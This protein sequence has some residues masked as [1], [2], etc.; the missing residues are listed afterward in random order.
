[1]KQYTIEEIKS[2]FVE[3]NYKWFDFH[4]VGIRSN[5]NLAN[6]F[7]DLIGIVNKNSIRWFTCTTN[8]GTH[9]LK[10]LLNP[11]GAALLKSNQYKICNPTRALNDKRGIVRVSFLRWSTWEILK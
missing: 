5:A 11:K 3:L 8:P 9:W 4:L 7:D 1:M 10:N 2:K 6:K